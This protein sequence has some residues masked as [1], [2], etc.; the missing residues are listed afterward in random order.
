ME[1]ERHNLT[2]N[3]ELVSVAVAA[4][5]GILA[6]YIKMQNEIVK[7]KSRVFSLEKSETKVQ[8]TLDVLVEGINEIK[9]MLAKQG[10]E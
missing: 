6:T 8:M 2:V 1:R 7:L 10:I 3:Y 5:S 9:I 4:L